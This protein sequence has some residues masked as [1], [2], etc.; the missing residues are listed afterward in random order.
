[1]TSGLLQLAVKEG[2]LEMLL[3][4]MAMDFTKSQYKVS[5]FNPEIKFSQKLWIFVQPQS[6]N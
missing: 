5:R 4:N 6:Y 2:L 1:M 3:S